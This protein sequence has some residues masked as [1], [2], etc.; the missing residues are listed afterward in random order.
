VNVVFPKVEHVAYI[1]RDIVLRIYIAMPRQRGGKAGNIIAPGRSSAAKKFVKKQVKALEKIQTPLDLRSKQTSK[2][3]TK[4]KITPKPTAS[5]LTLNKIKYDVKNIARAIRFLN[6]EI[7]VPPRYITQLGPSN[8]T[9]KDGNLFYLDRQIVPK[10]QVNQVVQQFDADPSKTGGRDRLH[11]HISK[12]YIGISKTAVNDYLKNSETHQLSAPVAKRV[13]NRSIVINKK[14]SYGQID[15]IDLQ[16]LSKLNNGFNWILVYV[17]LFSKFAA[18]EPLKTKHVGNVIAGMTNILESMKPAWRPHILQSDRGSEFDVE[19]SKAMKAKYNIKVIH[20]QAYNPTSQGA[21]ER[22]NKTI[23]TALNA[24]MTKYR[25]KRWVDLLKLVITNINTS[26]HSTTKAVPLEVMRGQADDGKVLKNIKKVA[27]A[28]IAGHEDTAFK[29]GDTV[30]VSLLTR[31]EERK[32]GSFR[33]S[34]G[35]NWSEDLYVVRKV[36]KP[37]TKFNKPTYLLRKGNRDLKKRYHANELLY[38]DQNKLIVDRSNPADRPVFD[39]KL[40]NL[41]ASNAAYRGTKMDK[42]P[43]DKI[44][45]SALS[46]RKPR[47]TRKANKKYKSSDYV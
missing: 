6:N 5:R 4:A 18:A 20:S 35:Q 23:K 33:K 24:Q 7:K 38:V 47:R 42:K 3:K 43:T 11:F 17:D 37:T 41:E 1:L 27:E 9:H 14:G 34:T 29:V 30:R 44:P 28:R 26:P 36:S 12:Q 25:S 21:V 45:A 19:F 31:S 46:E 2:T 8:F 39:K 22:L 13:Q 16:S 10:E 15:L 40:R 32:Q